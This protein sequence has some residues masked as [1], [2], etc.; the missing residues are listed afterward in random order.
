ML[1]FTTETCSP[2]TRLEKE[3]F[4]DSL[5]EMLDSYGITYNHIRSNGWDDLGEGQGFRKEYCR[6]IAHVVPLFV[7][8]PIGKYEDVN[9]S[10]SELLKLTKIF[11]G[12]VIEGESQSLGSCL[13]YRETQATTIDNL[14]LFI[15][16]CANFPDIK[17][18]ASP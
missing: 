12:A 4:F 11:N 18:P 3:G 6:K 1:I 14:R 13:D 15:E 10:T 7:L 8:V 5:H 17:E 2:C 16:E 9:V